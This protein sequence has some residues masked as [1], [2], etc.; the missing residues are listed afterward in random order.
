MIKIVTNIIEMFSLE[1][2]VFQQQKYPYLF[3][4][5]PMFVTWSTKRWYLLNRGEDLNISA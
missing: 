1:T 4:G 5:S 3:Y 2:A